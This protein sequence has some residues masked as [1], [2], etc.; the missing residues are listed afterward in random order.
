MLKNNQ[1]TISKKIL[2]A[3]AVY[4]DEEKKAVLK[5][6]DNKWLASGPLVKEFEEK[7]ASLFGKKY[8]IAV[9]SGSSANLVALQS[10]PVEKGS[11]VITPACTFST[12]V[13]SIV[14]AGL[15]PVFIDSVVGRYTIN[16]DFVERAIGPKTKVI[17]VPQLVGG[18][19]DMPKLR[20]IAN[21][22]KLILID[23][24]CDT[25]A[26]YIK[27][28]P[29]ATYSDLTTTSFYGSHIITALGFGGMVM[30]DSKE[31][32]DAIIVMRDWG[33]VGNDKEEFQ[34]RFDFEIDGIPYDSKFLYSKLG[35]NLKMNEAAAAFGLEQLKKLNKFLKIR[36][37]NFQQLTIYFSKYQKWFYI[38]QL[39]AGAKT[40]W[41]A[42]PLTVKK[43]APFKRYDFLKHMESKGIQTRVLFSGN[44]TRHPVY[45]DIKFR[46]VGKLTNADEIMASSLLFGCHQALTKKDILYI[47]N[48]AEEFF[49]KYL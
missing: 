48:C 10:I 32:R 19:C 12:T 9:N 24:S 35:Y 13:S 20:K 43:K 26:P 8:G 4:G 25:I 23:D 16:E 18:I 22:H 46:V 14:H 37:Y 33:R 5:S 7:V 49:K 31:I 38:P 17:M 30:T 42:F 28:K 15:V 39:L 45:K 27:G 44:I 11:E 6:M 2:Y 41:L 3:E 34:N 21:K 36:D 40:N 29:A 47:C 1:Q